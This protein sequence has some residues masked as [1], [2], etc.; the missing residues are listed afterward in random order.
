MEIKSQHIFEAPLIIQGLILVNL[1][2]SQRIR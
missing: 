1:I 2:L